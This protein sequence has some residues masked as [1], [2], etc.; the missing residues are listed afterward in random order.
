[1]AGVFLEPVGHEQRIRDDGISSG[2]KRLLSRA[3]VYRGPSDAVNIQSSASRKIICRPNHI[4]ATHLKN[5][6]FSLK[7]TFEPDFCSVRVP[8][9]TQRKDKFAVLFPG[10]CHAERNE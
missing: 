6:R 2:G 10:T 4:R 5:P 7:I 9:N 3:R 8:G 1:M